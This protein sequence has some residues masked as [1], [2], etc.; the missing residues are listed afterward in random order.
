MKCSS[1]HLVYF[2]KQGL[3]LPLSISLVVMM[4]ILVFSC[5]TIFQKLC[6]VPGR[7]PCVAIYLRS[8]PGTS[9]LM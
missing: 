9:P 3:T 7:Q 4:M 5:Q 8:D 6:A 1:Y 2:K